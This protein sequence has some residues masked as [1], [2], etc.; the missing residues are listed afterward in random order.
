MA[1]ADLEAQLGTLGIAPLEGDAFAPIG[2]DVWAPIEA[3]SGGRFPD[4]V[5]WLFGRYGG[6]RFPDGAAYADPRT[7]DASFGWFLDAH[8]LAEA[9]EVTR[10]RMPDTLVPLVADGGGNYVCVDLE[11]GAAVAWQHD[12]LRD[13]QLTA[14]AA[15]FE[16]FVRSLHADVA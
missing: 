4:A 5:R 13:R 11:S 3:A 8:E 2:P 16:A 9:F 7:P 6:F 12:A 10:G 1:F 15:T 14:V